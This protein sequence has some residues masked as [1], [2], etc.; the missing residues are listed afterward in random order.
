MYK[1]SRLKRS[2]SA[3][4]PLYFLIMRWSLVIWCPAFYHISLEPF[5]LHLETLADTPFSVGKNLWGVPMIVPTSA[6]WC[7]V[8][9]DPPTPSAG[10]P[11]PCPIPPPSHLPPCLAPS[12]TWPTQG[13]LNWVTPWCHWAETAACIGCTSCSDTDVLYGTFLTALGQ[14]KCL[15]LA[16]G[17]PFIV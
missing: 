1:Y 16:Q 7:W 5:I 11:S 14:R 8:A 10:T 15:A 13:Q 17:C 12:R 4:P 2:E 9:R 3:W 6:V